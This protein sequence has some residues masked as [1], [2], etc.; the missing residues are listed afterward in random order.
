[1]KYTPGPWFVE[2]WS[3][4]CGNQNDPEIIARTDLDDPMAVAN[5]PNAHGMTTAEDNARLIA[6]APDLLAALEVIAEGAEENWNDWAK[7]GYETTE[8]ID[9]A[10]VT[11][12][13]ARAAIAKA[14]PN[15]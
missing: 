1:M 9:F 6:A 12:E 14:K 7:N 4:L 2:G 8:P 11:K 10:R 15:G 3:V 13:K 5:R